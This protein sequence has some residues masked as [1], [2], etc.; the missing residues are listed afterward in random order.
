MDEKT[1][2]HLTLASQNQH[3]ADRLRF[4]DPAGISGNNDHAV[5]YLWSAVISFYSAVHYVNAYLWE[6]G[7][8]APRNH[9]E[10]E[11]YLY[12][13]RRLSRTAL[14]YDALRDRGFQARYDPRSRI[15]ADDAQQAMDELHTIAVLVRRELGTN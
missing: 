13:D 14:S 5:Q 4:L 7:R 3:F 2:G 9:T 11:Q 10:R 15:A 12:A 8:F 1:R 6:R